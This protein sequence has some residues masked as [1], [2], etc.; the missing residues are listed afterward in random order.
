MLTELAV[1]GLPCIAHA[2]PEIPPGGWGGS[3]GQCLLPVGGDCSSW[4]TV[5]A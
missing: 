3:R 5:V 2:E 4:E 1:T